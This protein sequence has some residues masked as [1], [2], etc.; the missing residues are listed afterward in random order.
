M[1][2]RGG[3]G[4]TGC[5]GGAEERGGG[6]RNPDAEIKRLEGPEA[7]LVHPEGVKR[8]E[9]G[10]GSPAQQIIDAL[11]KSVPRPLSYEN[12]HTKDLRR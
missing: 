10:K 9:G 12:W 1:G 7:G 2:G 11:T 6:A 4:E 3:A 8:E 5:G